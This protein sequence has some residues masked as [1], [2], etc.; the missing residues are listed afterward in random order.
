MVNLDSLESKPNFMRKINLFMLVIALG[1]LFLSF[2]TSKLSKDRPEERL[3]WKLGAQ[4]YTF[5]L[6]SF[7]E[8]LDKLD[9]C[10]LGYV[11][12]YPGQTIGAGSTEKM[13]YQLSSEG[14]RLVKKLLKEKGVTLHA[15]GVVGAQDAEEWDKVFA[16]AKD[17]GIQVINV[18]PSDAHLDIVSSL[19]DK[20]QI[21]AALHN[22][23]EPSKYW[24]PEVVLKSLEGRSKLMGAAADVG[25]W[26]RSGLDPIACL[27]QLEGHIFHLHFKD[28]NEFGNKKA[29]DVH[30]GT[31][32]LPLQG[33]IDELKRQKFKGMLS[34]EYEYNWE[35]S[36][37]DVCVSVAN[38]RK[39]IK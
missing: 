28:L 22:H 16:F 27:K 35:N 8:A 34:V 11:E 18:E 38:F 32:K 25:H 14:R 19:C 13:G 37:K 24:N 6:F 39:L 2:S 30:W 26:M 31:G 33:V 36:K 3:G 4:A 20:Y 23:P 10:N 29:H 17:M 12:A 7:A 5:R 1:V 15:F 21:R 9:S